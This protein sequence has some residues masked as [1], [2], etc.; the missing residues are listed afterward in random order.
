MKSE[1]TPNQRLLLWHLGLRGGRALQ[2]E[3]EYKQIPK[4]RKELERRGFLRVGNEGRA[5]ALELNGIS[6]STS[7]AAGGGGEGIAEPW[8]EDG[9]AGSEPASFVF[10][11]SGAVAESGGG[12]NPTDWK[13]DVRQ[14]GLS[15][16]SHARNLSGFSAC[17]ATQ[18]RF[19]RPSN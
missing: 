5:I 9:D 11:A 19:P 16:C 8:G 7:S 6:F 14:S 2:K 17:R 15:F 4:D 18:R 12:H 10:M 13:N 1:L 3:V